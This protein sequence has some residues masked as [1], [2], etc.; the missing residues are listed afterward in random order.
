MS[1]EI[2]KIL[3]AVARGE[4]SPEEGEMLIKAVQEKEREEIGPKGDF[5]E[6]EGDYILGEN[7]I[8]EEDLVLSKKK[9]IIRGKIKGDL[10]LI[11][12]ETFFSGEVEGDLAVIGGKIEFDG[13]T[14]K[15]DLALIGV[16]ESGKTPVV[17]GDIARISN[18]FV[19]GILKMVSPFISNI[20]V[21]SK[22]KVEG[23]E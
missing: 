1:E 12:C 22:K 3:E 6:R 14:V 15:G 2:R 17:E 11:N 4:I 20:S 16:K 7:E 5:S 13:G 23:K 18:F 21:S 9:A 10:A 8:V 19:S